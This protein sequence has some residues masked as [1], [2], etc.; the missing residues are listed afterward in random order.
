MRCQDCGDR[1]AI[2]IKHLPLPN[3]ERGW[4]TLTNWETLCPDCIKSKAREFDRIIKAN[5]RDEK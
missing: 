4:F 2:K 1:N 3:G 5:G